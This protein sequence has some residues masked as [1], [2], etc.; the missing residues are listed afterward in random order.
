MSGLHT[1]NVSAIKIALHTDRFKILQ[2][3]EWKKIEKK[4]LGKNVIYKL[5]Y[6]RND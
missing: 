2:K 5:K 3:C 6:S 1:G 4:K